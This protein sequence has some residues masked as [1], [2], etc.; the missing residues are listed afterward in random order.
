MVRSLVRPGKLVDGQGFRLRGREMTRLETFVDAGFAFVVAMLALAQDDLPRTYA[1]MI[2]LLRGVPAFVVCLSIV[3]L[4][5]TAHVEFSQRYGLDDGPTK[6]LSGALVAVLMI[7]VFPLKFMFTI[8]FAYFIPPLRTSVYT[9][10]ISGPNDL[11]VMFAVMSAGYIAMH[12]VLCLLTW[13]AWRKREVLGLDARERFLTKAQFGAFGVYIAVGAASIS[14]AVAFRGSLWVTSAGWI[15]A[16]IGV[17]MPLYWF[18][19]GRVMNEPP[20]ERELIPLDEL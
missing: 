8:F 11:S 20:K 5:W 2:D 9:P 3:M 13:H 16:F 10:P 18:I 15:Y 17:L 12:A 7:Y 6:F 19:T 4:F 14:L 1:G